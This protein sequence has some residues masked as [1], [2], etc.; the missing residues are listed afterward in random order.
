MKIFIVGAGFTG[1]QL[2]RTLVS[3][4]NEVTLIDNDQA[5]ALQSSDQIDCAV[6]HSDGNSLEVLEAA[7]IASADALVALTDDD[8][9]NMIICSLVDSVYPGIFKIARVRN[10]SYYKN[11]AT[12]AKKHASQFAAGQRP[13][14]GIDCMI[15]PDVE[16]AWAI[17]RAIAAGA[18]G[19]T[20]KLGSD[21]GITTIPIMEG[22]PLDGV[23]VKR[24]AGIPDWKYLIAYV[25]VPDAPDL[26]P[27]GETV[28]KAGMRIGVLSLQ[29]E[30][31]K[32]LRL[33][34]A[35]DSSLRK[36]VIFGAGRVGA[37][38][39]ERLIGGK[40][41][42]FLR[43]V[44]SLGK[45]A[46]QEIVIVDPDMEKAKEASERFPEARVLCGDITEEALFEEE[47]L[48]SC[49]LM[50]SA[51]P[52]YE[53]DLIIASYL[54]SRGAKRAISL[55]SHSAFGEIARKLGVDV[56]IPM[57][58]TVVDGIMSHLRGK[59]ITAVHTVCN[60]SFE[61]VECEISPESEKA[62]K[63]LKEIS[64]GGNYLV[65]LLSPSGHGKW[66][67]PK[68]E[69]I[70]APGSRIVMIMRAGEHVHMRKFAPLAGGERK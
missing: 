27:C 29:S 55:T 13:V 30:I 1:T 40:R 39:A 15:H 51:S 42:G 17:L 8:E 64:E 66:E 10:Y 58:D 6:V 14:F 54:K 47:R 48:D 53:R 4:G 9:T 3:E 49:D 20:T 38:V 5:R 34:K 70:L 16:A 35:G 56:A 67:V 18:V 60:G 41:N 31:P 21:Y 65:L 50:I 68:G 44:F 46:G 57:R 28:L 11:T 32:L 63:S 22:S 24:L 36:I 37:T 45:H 52:N 23:A 25:D 33:G 7:G 2:A 59:N 62:G 69:T 12:T 43:R 19:D 61:I 26:L